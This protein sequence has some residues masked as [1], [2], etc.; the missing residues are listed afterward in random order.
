M[1]QQGANPLCDIVTKVTEEQLKSY[2]K[3]LKRCPW[4]WSH[5]ATK[6]KGNSISGFQ[7]VI[8]KKWKDIAYLMLEV[9]GL[10]LLYALKVNI[11]FG[12]RIGI[13]VIDSHNRIY[14]YRIL[15]LFHEH[16][17][18]RISKDL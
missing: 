3:E 17:D 5:T 18:S 4:I 13:I 9:S 11:C 6:P 2:E 15:P 8:Q 16:F 14:L 1:L 10:P 7:A 12:M